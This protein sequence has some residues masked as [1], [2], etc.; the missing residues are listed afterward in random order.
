MNWFGFTYW[1]HEIKERIR[2]TFIYLK[3][4]GKQVKRIWTMPYDWK[5]VQSLHRL[6]PRRRVF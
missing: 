4:Y 1:L 2:Y 3:S 6:K 5:E